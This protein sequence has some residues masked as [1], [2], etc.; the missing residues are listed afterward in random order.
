MAKLIDRCTGPYGLWKVTDA[1]YKRAEQIAF[2]GS[3][4]TDEADAA[5]Q[6]IRYCRG[7]IFHRDL[8]MDALNAIRAKTAA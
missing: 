5:F 2:D 8:A 4:S 1:E 3:A 7:E 6:L